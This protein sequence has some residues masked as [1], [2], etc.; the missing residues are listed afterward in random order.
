MNSNVKSSHANYMIPDWPVPDCVKSVITLRAKGCSKPPFN[1]FNLADHVGDDLLAVLANRKQLLES[2]NLNSE[3]IWLDQVHGSRVV[4]APE[5]ISKPS[6]DACYTNI[7]GQTCVV[8]TADCLPVLFCN[9]NGSKV[10]AAHAGWRGLCAGILRKTLSCFSPNETV[11]A[12]LGPAIGPKVFEVGAD[13]LEAFLSGAQNSQ[14]VALI[15]LAFKPCDNGRYFADLYALAR[16]ELKCAGIEHV[17]GGLSCT[18][19]QPDKFF[20]YRRD[21]ITGRNASLIWLEKA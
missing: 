9:Q 19:S 21:K 14:H 20:S 8:L 2:L 10:A 4:Y 1:D 3:P 11:L 7:I 17:Y 18:Y 6:A 15:K 13:V 12:Y 5:V 16:A